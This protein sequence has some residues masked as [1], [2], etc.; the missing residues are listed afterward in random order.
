MRCVLQAPNVA[1]AG[2]SEGCNYVS[3]GVPSP[4]KLIKDQVT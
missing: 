3:S 4:W 1:S 2:G